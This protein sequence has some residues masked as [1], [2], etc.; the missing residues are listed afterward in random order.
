M[1]PAAHGVARAVR[2]PPDLPCLARQARFSRP[3]L[4]RT[5]AY[6]RIQALNELPGLDRGQSNDGRGKNLSYLYLLLD[7]QLTHS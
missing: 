6:Y 3:R 7:E 5:I 4:R 2:W 1:P